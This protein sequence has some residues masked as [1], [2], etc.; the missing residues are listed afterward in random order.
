LG[1][2]GGHPYK[3]LGAAMIDFHAHRLEVKAELLE[4]INRDALAQLDQAEQEVFGAH[5]VLIET[6][7]FFARQG[8]HLLGSG[9]KVI[10]GFIAHNY[11]SKWD[12][13]YCLSNPA[14]GGADGLKTA[15]LT[16]LRRSRTM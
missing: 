11:S 12:H 9:R 1:Q 7:G 10:H 2:S 6:G 5:K 4:N 3:A 8:E 14:S 15:W 13:S 16:G